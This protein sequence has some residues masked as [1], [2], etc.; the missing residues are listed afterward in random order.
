LLSLWKLPAGRDNRNNCYDRQAD[1][2]LCGDWVDFRKRWAAIHVG[3][4]VAQD[5]AELARAAWGSEE[6]PR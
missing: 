6:N 1:F 2:V 5:A 4:T 3:E